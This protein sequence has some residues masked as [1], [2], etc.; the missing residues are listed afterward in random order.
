MT[1]S[2][3]LAGAYVAAGILRMHCGRLRAYRLFKTS[4]LI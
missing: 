4:I 1:L 2:A 3:L